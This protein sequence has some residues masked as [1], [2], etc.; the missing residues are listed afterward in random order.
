MRDHLDNVP[1]IVQVGNQHVA[2]GIGVSGLDGVID[3]DDR[4]PD[5]RGV[6]RPV[7]VE[8]QV[9]GV[10]GSGHTGR[11]RHGAGQRQAKKSCSSHRNRVRMTCCVS[12]D[13]L[14]RKSHQLRVIVPVR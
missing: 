11:K 8:H 14:F 5:R 2:G 7:Q 9:T 10:L 1:A 4:A 13:A 3:R 12:G 6:T